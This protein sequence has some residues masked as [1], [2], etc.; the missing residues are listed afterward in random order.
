[1]SYMNPCENTVAR[2]HG[3]GV[4]KANS[5]EIGGDCNFLTAM[6]RVKAIR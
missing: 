1:M 6:H 3:Y 4:S 2:E 5:S